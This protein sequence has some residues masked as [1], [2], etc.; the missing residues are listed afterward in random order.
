MELIAVVVV[1]RVRVAGALKLQTNVGNK[2]A[3]IPPISKVVQDGEC[4]MISTQR[5]LEYLV[6]LQGQT[7]QPRLRFKQRLICVFCCSYK[8]PRV[9]VSSVR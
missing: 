8:A 1:E 7:N 4:Q 9:L 6:R 2:V 5:A 3:L